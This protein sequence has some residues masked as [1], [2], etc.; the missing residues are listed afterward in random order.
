V[1][2]LAIPIVVASSSCDVLALAMPIVVASSSCIWSAIAVIGR[3]PMRER[4]GPCT[5]VRI[6]GSRALAIFFHHTVGSSTR[7]GVRP[8]VVGLPEIVG[9]G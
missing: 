8:V 3:S 6:V 5:V 4:R 1:P 9:A 2:P 7:I